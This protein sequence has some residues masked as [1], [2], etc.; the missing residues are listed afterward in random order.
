MTPAELC[1]YIIEGKI[2]DDVPS[3]DSDHAEQGRDIWPKR[4][5]IFVELAKEALNQPTTAQKGG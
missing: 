2:F 3:G 1:E 5:D 4:Y